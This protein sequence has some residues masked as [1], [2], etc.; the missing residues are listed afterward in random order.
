MHNPI[1]PDTKYIGSPCILD[2]VHLDFRVFPVDRSACVEL[3]E[4][5]GNPSL[6]IKSVG[7]KTDYELNNTN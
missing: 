2:I 5:F 4:V 6:V 1:P 3:H 7:F